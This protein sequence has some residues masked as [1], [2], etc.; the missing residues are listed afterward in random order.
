[1]ILLSRIDFVLHG[2]VDVCRPFDIEGR[3]RD[4]GRHKNTL[5]LPN[6]DTVWILDRTTE[7]SVDYSLLL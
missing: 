7:R 4:E 2:L 1:M 5:L 6:R 3:P